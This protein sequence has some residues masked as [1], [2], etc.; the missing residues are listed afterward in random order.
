MLVNE[1]QDPYDIFKNYKDE[2]TVTT[3]GIKLKDTNQPHFNFHGN[4]ED[5]SIH[6][7]KEWILIV[8][9]FIFF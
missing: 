9:S 7:P 6:S 2:I 5:I 8:S 3:T 4:K 1:N